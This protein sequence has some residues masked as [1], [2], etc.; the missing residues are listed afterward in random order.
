[1][2][3]APKR[4]HLLVDLALFAA[5]LALAALQH[6]STTDL[7]WSLWVA[8]LTVGYS[9]IVTS[10]VGSLAHGSS[11]TFLSPRPGGA[12]ADPTRKPA[13][14]GLAALPFNAFILFGTVML[15][16]LGRTAFAVLVLAVVST[17]V[18]LAGVLRAKPGFEFL[19]DPGRGLARTIVMLPAAI[20]MLGFFTVHFGMFHFIHGLFLNGFFP[21]VAAT[22]IGKSPGGVFGIVGV[23]AREAF[24]R[25]WPF[26]AASAL[27]RLPAYAA[28]W[29]TADGSMMVR[30]YVNVIRMHVMIFVFALLSA[31]GLR[32]YGLYP[33]L[34]VYFLPLGALL[35]L[36]RR[37]VRPAGTALPS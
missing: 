34:V 31:A 19:P 6:W 22:P 32:S 11:A 17:A 25:F 2:N 4:C 3:P 23:C 20:F 35:S 27:S 24:T 26:V 37:K 10:I 18:A 14:A 13:S 21:L 12:P 30:P 33:L 36:V 5:T 7:V 28:A 8:S 29:G 9:L 16:G 15:F 1:M